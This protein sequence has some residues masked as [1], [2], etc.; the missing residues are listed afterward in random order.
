MMPSGLIG[1]LVGK[2]GATIQEYSS[3]FNVRINIDRDGEE[4]DGKKKVEIV[5]EEKDV[6][7]AVKAINDKI[8][9]AG[10]GGKLK[11]HFQIHNKNF[12]PLQTTSHVKFTFHQ[13]QQTTN[14]KCLDLEFR[15]ASISTTSIRSRSTFP[16]M[17]VRKSKTKRFS[18]SAIQSFVKFFWKTLE[19][20]ATPSRH[21]FKSTR[22]RSFLQNAI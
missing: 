22:S 21:Q 14:L 9:S 4:I 20:R 11:K 13:S 17:A 7:N 12:F 8:M 10:D 1:R 2:A 6:A 3:E 18:N 16:A 19:S 5:G 15:L